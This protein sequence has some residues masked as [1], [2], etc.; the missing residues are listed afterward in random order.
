[1][2]DF[3]LKNFTFSPEDGMFNFG[4]D[5][6]QTMDDAENDPGFFLPN[7]EGRTEFL[8]PDPSRVPQ[9]PAVDQAK[10][11]YAA[12][13]A[14][15]RTQELFNNMNPHRRVLYGVLRAMQ[16]PLSE[17]DADKTIEA[18]R[19]HKFS[20]YSP[21]NICT[22]LETAG[23]VERVQED[24]SPYEEYEPEPKIV[25]IDG[26]EYWEPTPAPAPF[27]QIT[28]AGQAQLDSYN[29]ASKLERTFATEPEY[30]TLY[31]RVLTLASEGDGKTMK[32]LSAAVDNDPL[33]AT[34]PRS[35]FVQHFVE[36]LERGE[37]VAW[38]GKAWKT[39]D[40]GTQALNEMLADVEDDYKPDEAAQPAQTES[41]GVN[42]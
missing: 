33:V 21:A 15:E 27:W 24:G 2:T 26:E 22:M 6:P 36:A 11:E 20:V 7:K 12:R 39:T 10:P 3:D 9:M 18:L 28:E 29:P 42:W 13:P 23:A 1:M 8:P 19:A 35:F 38:N 41:D 14:A 34:E 32:Q 31:K 40:I 30:L 4:S 5:G 25:L 37:A 17:D 16:K